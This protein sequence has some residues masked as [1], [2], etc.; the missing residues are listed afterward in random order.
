MFGTILTHFCLIFPMQQVMLVPHCK[1]HAG[2]VQP[3][4]HYD[5][6]TSYISPLYEISFIIVFVVGVINVYH[7]F[8]SK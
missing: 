3:A 2:C 5:L 7:V 6:F 1:L 4:V 8:I